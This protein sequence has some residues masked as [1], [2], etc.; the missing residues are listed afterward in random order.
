MSERFFSQA[1]ITGSRVSLEGAEAHHLARVMRAT[2][3]TQVVLFDGSGAEFHATVEAVDRRAVQLRIDK[4]VEADRESPCRLTIA[5]ALPK[6]DR[7]RWMIEK[8]VE[9]GVHR[10]VPLL[11][12]RST[13]R[14]NESACERLRRTVVEASKQC[15]RNRLMQV[16]R[17]VELT[18]LLQHEAPGPIDGA[19]RKA[20]IAHPRRDQP[21]VSDTPVDTLGQWPMG[22]SRTLLCA[23]IG[24]EGGFD[25]DEIR[26]AVAQ[27]WRL[28]D[29]GPRVLRIETAAVAVAAVAAAVCLSDRGDPGL[30]PASNTTRPPIDPSAE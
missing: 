21:E 10:F 27:G 9:L 17:P 5:A 2:P 6:G 13:V 8:L 26:A 4:R 28:L 22:S 14:P 1:P 23:A 3:G 19:E 11:T 12:R 7:Q 15:G 20:W 29:L 16:D 24:P 30:P 25:P 18:A